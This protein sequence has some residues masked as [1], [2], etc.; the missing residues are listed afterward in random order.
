M[1]P[2]WY[3]MDK[4]VKAIDLVAEH[5]E[6]TWMRGLPYFELFNALH[7][8]GYDWVEEEGQWKKRYADTDSVTKVFGSD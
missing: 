5:D 8:Y 4:M 2:I 3:T 6:L 1:T 7:D